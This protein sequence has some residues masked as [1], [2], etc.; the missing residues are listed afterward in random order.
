MLSEVAGVSAAMLSKLANECRRFYTDDGG[1]MEGDW[2][3]VLGSIAGG[4]TLSSNFGYNIGHIVSQAFDDMIMTAL[5]KAG[6]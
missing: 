4:L 3:L 1:F 6:V 5:R 2:V